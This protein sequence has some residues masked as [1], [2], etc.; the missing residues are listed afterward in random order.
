MRSRRKVGYLAPTIR[1]RAVGL[2]FVWSYTLTV[3]YE[4]ERGF[5]KRESRS[6][7]LQISILKTFPSL[8]EV[9]RKW[10]K[11]QTK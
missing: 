11:C 7:H 2:C 10:V 5:H 8:F 4:E 6:S 1:R 9:P 3:S